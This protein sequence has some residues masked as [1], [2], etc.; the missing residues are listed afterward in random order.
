MAAPVTSAESARMALL[1]GTFDVLLAHVDR[2]LSWVSELSPETSVIVLGRSPIPDVP[3]LLIVS[4][5][6]QPLERL[7]EQIRWHLD[8][9][10]R[11]SAPDPANHDIVR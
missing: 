8:G 9:S 6:P 7:V 1:E 11:L 10:S 3:S 2:D 4:Q 5:W